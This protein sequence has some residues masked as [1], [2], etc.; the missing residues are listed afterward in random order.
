M[1]TMDGLT[2]LGSAAALLFLCCAGIVFIKIYM[3]FIKRVIIPAVKNLL[4]SLF[5]KTSF[6]ALLPLPIHSRH[7]TDVINYNHNQINFYTSYFK[8]LS[9]NCFCFELPAK[10]KNIP[11]FP[12]KENEFRLD[13]SSV[14]I[15]ILCFNNAQTSKIKFLHNSDT[16]SKFKKS[17]YFIHDKIEEAFDYIELKQLYLNPLSKLVFCKK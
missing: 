3:E 12:I 11:H 2:I 13:S 14:Y 17:F 10:A 9:K 15:I 16:F 4:I 7:V 1:A 6:I 8:S 5:Y